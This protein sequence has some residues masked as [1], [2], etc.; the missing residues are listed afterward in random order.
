MS[1]LGQCEELTL[2]F[3]AEAKAVADMRRWTRSHFELW[4]MPWLADTAELCVSELVTNVITH[5]GEG[6]PAT[7]QL[8]MQA[9]N[10]RI[11]LTDPAPR[12][13]PH[14]QTAEPHQ[15]SGRGLPLLDALTTNW[16]TTQHPAGHKTVW[17]ELGGARL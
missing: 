13:L 2:T 11:E 10:P 9:P 5:V 1:E 16:G 17:C 8:F 12:F 7:L 15:E 4:G 14:A 3:L 6:T